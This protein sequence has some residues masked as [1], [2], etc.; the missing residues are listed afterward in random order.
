MEL[1][2][3]LIKQA[4]GSRAAA[5]AKPAEVVVH[6]NTGEHVATLKSQQ[7]VVV[8]PKLIHQISEVIGQENIRIISISR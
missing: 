6:I 3:G 5:G 4:G 7:K 8:E 1:V 2:S